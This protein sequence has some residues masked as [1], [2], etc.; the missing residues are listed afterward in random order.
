M[1]QNHE[2]IIYPKAQQDLKD[3]FEYIS[4]VLSNPSAANKLIKDISDSIKNLP[5]FLLSCPQVSNENLKDQTLRKLLI[6]KYIIF[7]R[8]KGN[9]IQIVRVLYGMSDYEKY[10]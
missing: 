7:Y 8:L 3:I 5:S 6:K 9:E 10:L 4:I 1:V 2:I